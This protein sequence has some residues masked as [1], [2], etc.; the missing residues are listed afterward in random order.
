VTPPGRHFSTTSRP[1]ASGWA[2]RAACS[3][4]LAQAEAAQLVVRGV[5]EGRHEGAAGDGEAGAD[6]LEGADD[7]VQREEEGGGGLGAAAGVEG[8]DV[9][10][11][12]DD[13]GAGGAAGGAGGG[14]D[15][16][17]VEVVVAVGAVGGG[18]AVEAG[19][20]AGEDGEFLAGVVADDADLGADEGFLWGEAEGGGLHEAQGRGVVLEEAEVVDGVAVERAQR[21]LLVV[22]EDGLG[23]DGSGVN[24]VTIGEDDAPL[25]VDDE[26]GRLRGS[27]PFGVEGAG[28]VDADRNDG[29]ADSLQTVAPGLRLGVGVRGTGFGAGGGHGQVGKVSSPGRSRKGPG[30]VG[31]RMLRWMQLHGLRRSCD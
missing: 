2:A 22:E 27:V 4:L 19:E 6:P 5:D 26:G 24:D 29:G 11:D 8:D 28:G 20:G 1:V 23:D 31:P 17:G 18:G 25:G 30:W 16:E 21:D 3:L 10:V 12:V 15:V 13:G 9:A 7:P 14:L